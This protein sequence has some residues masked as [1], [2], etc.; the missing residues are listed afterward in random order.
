MPTDFKG[1]YTTRD[2]NI[3][4]NNVSLINEKL[5]QRNLSKEDR[6]V[7][8]G[9][10][11]E[12]SGGDPF[13][14]STGST[15]QGL[16][17]WGADRYRPKYQNPKKELNNQV[18][19]ILNSV[20]DAKTNWSHGGEGSGYKSLEETYNDFHNEDTPFDKKVRAFSYGYVRPK[21]KEASYQNR[22]KVSKQVLDKLVV[23][24][25][26]SKPKA[27][28]WKPSP[29]TK[30]LQ[31]SSRFSE[32]GS[33]NN[34]WDSLSM[35]DKAE[36]MKVAIQNGVT[37]LPEI[38]EAYNKFAKG[39]P[40]KWTMQD[41][42]GY[43]YWRQNL[44][45]NLRDTNDNDCDMRAAY[46]AGMQPMWNNEDKD[47][48]LQSR[49]P[50]SGRILKAPHHPTYLK[51][52][53]EDSSPGYY[54]TMDSKGNTYTETW[55]G[56]TMFQK[57]EVEV[58]Y[59]AYGGNLFY[60][61]G[62]TAMKDLDTPLV[63]SAPN[64]LEEV[65]VYPTFMSLSTH[66]PIVSQYPFTGHSQIEAWTKTPDYLLSQGDHYGATVTKKGSDV[67]YNLITNNCSDATMNALE[68]L[69][70]VK[71]NKGLFTT[72]GDA[73]QFFIDNFNTRKPNDD[74]TSRPSSRTKHIGDTELY[75]T[76]SLND[77]YKLENLQEEQIKRNIEAH[78]K[79][80]KFE[81]GG[82]LDANFFGGGGKKSSR[83]NNSER[84]LNYLMSRGI[85]K[86]GASAIVGTLQAESSLDPTIH[87]QMK[88]DTGEGLAQW[89][90][91]RKNVF[92]KTLEA[93]EP[94]AK[95]RYGSIDKVP[96]E[97][98]LDV[99]MAER[100][101]VTQAISN[102]QDVGSATDIM[103][104]GY[105]NGGGSIN[106]MASKAQ[107]NKI[108]GKWNNGYDN[109]MKRRLGNASSLL[110]ISIDPS[111]YTLSQGVFD[112]IDAQIAGLP[113]IDYNTVDPETIY[114]APTI[115]ETLFQ[116]P[117]QTIEAPV[118]NPKQERLEG[119]QRLGAIMGL[120]G[121]SN[122]IAGIT[123]SSSPLLSYI[124][125]IYS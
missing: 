47:Y 5:K 2:R 103:L 91:S 63:P 39:G 118:Y 82:F 22:L 58:P 79:K 36:M 66:Y 43:R 78:R 83:T 100:P 55:P 59:K 116:Q 21:G 98:Q 120:M 111:Q 29:F 40:T 80:Q 69:S 33:L 119:I 77:L 113:S 76:I 9:S 20:N 61:G 110:G 35:K 104:R 10:I 44:P 16:L 32:G 60:E 68:K 122:P 19:Y 75:T 18:D 7:I 15:Y 71:Y 117:Q 121:Q 107:M 51:A 52:L 81:D 46:K 12:E 96:F 37:T 125:Q 62:E 56:N 72:P 105:E 70:G 45:K 17:Q 26:L 85:S 57:K 31:M 11:I 73:R 90:G 88:G 53:I 101:D 67:D 27:K 86:T 42:A 38:K 109:Q 13:A 106:N 41:E 124:G 8:L 28:E 64:E 24:E 54:P 93:I 48:H 14:Q 123:G 99:V 94:G 1:I 87:A 89:T 102:A 74:E 30:P 3:D 95:K 34:Y 114:K 84:A 49:D 92:W 108:Y 97:R 4:V 23:D 50:E 6:A 112:N 115:D 25:V 65:E